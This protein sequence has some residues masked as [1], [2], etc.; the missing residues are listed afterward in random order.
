MPDRYEIILAGIG[1]QGLILSGLVLASASAIFDGKNAVQTQS[2]APLARGAPSRS[3][4]IISDKEIDYPEVIKADLFLALDQTSFDEFGSKVKQGG[5]IIIDSDLVNVKDDL[6]DKVMKIPFT[7]LA[8]EKTGK[9]I[10]ASMIALGFISKLTGIV[11][12]LALFEA[13]KI[14][15]PEGTEELN[16]NAVKI[17][18]EAV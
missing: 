6:K 4:I 14:K 2:Y 17:G 5:K 10:T 7:K 13:I 8:K 11:T 12:P 3:E 16:I 15:A 18:L 9:R 1:G